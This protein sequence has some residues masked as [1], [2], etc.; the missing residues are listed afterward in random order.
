MGK[1]KWKQ[2][3]HQ[4]YLRSFYNYEDPKTSK[5]SGLLHL[6]MDPDYIARRYGSKTPAAAGPL[7]HY[8]HK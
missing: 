4:R 3:R 8:R 1:Q 7:I 2:R 5:E 6:K